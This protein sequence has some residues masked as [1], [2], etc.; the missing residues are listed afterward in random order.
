MHRHFAMEE[1]YNSFSSIQFQL[2]G[3]K[4]C[5]CKIQVPIL[6]VMVY[7]HKH[8]ITME[9]SWYSCFLNFD[10]LNLTLVLQKIHIQVLVACPLNKLLPNVQTEQ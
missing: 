2:S 9:M 8:Y 10:R 7:A 4:E 6:K 1:L 5:F 3:S